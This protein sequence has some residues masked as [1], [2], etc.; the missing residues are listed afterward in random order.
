MAETEIKDAEKPKNRTRDAGFEFFII[1]M[2]SA[3]VAMGTY[4]I[5]FGIATFF[6]ILVLYSIVSVATEEIAAAIKERE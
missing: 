5:G 3:G 4:N 1:V 6:G 2:T